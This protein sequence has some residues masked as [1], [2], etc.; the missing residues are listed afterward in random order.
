MKQLERTIKCIHHIF[1]SCGKTDRP[2]K[3]RYWESLKVNIL[4]QNEIAWYGA[5]TSN[6]GWYTNIKCGLVQITIE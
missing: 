1:C 3:R 4:T 2:G 5:L 6:R